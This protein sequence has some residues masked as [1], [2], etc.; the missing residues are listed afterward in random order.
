MN[1]DLAAAIYDTLLPGWR[2]AKRVGRNRELCAPYRED[3]H[4]SLHI[5]EEKLVWIDRATGEG[6]GAW[7][8]ARKMLGEDDARDLLAR[9]EPDQT[10]RPLTRRP[11]PKSANNKGSSVGC[12][13]DPPRHELEILGD[14]TRAQVEALKRTRRL[15]DVETLCRLDVKLVR[16]RFRKDADSRWS[17]WEEWLGF[18]ALSGSWKLWALNRDGIE[19]TDAQGKLIR[20]NVGPISLIPSPALR[21]GAFDPVPIVLDVEGESDLLAALEAGFT[22]VV[23]STGGAGSLGAHEANAE[24]LRTRRIAEV[25]VL[26]DRDE[27]GQRGAEKRAEWWL[28]LGVPARVPS[29]PEQLGQ[30]GDLRDYL[31]GTVAR[32]GH[33]ALEPLGDAAALTALAGA[34]PLREPEI[35]APE[36]SEQKADDDGEELDGAE[37]PESGALELPPA[38]LRGSFREFIEYLRPVTGASTAHAFASWWAVLGAC[39]GPARSGTW[40][41]RVVSVVYAIACGGTGDHKT[42]AMDLAAD[43]LPEG[44]RQVSGC[45]SDAGLFDA[46]EGDEG[47]TPQPVLLHFDELGFLLKMAALSGSTLNPMLNRLWNAPSYLDRILSKRNKDGGARRLEWPFTCLLGG[48]QPETFWRTIGDAD[49]AIASGFVNRLAVFA[50][51]PGPSLLRTAAPDECA[52]EA[53][54]LHLAELRGLQPARVALAPNAEALWDEFAEDHEARIRSLPTL[55]ASVAKRVRD[56]VARLALTYAVDGGRTEV[57]TSDLMAA[58]EVG[59]YL[60]RS[61]RGLLEGR[62]ADRG[63]GRAS[64][65]E[66]IA[67]R[68]LVKRPG[69]WQ[70]ARDLIRSWPNAQAPSSVELRRI[71]Q[72][73]DEIDRQREG[74]NERYRLTAQRGGPTRHPTPNTSESKAPSVGCRVGGASHAE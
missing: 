24:W 19:R 35:S 73:M 13:V 31:N 53:L 63:P 71:L 1:P 16:A 30:G 52:A 60:E 41:G 39:I 57:S 44:V 46:L 17:P 33:P 68:L 55:L 11:T 61:Y 49:L 23:T 62:Q 7:D 3:R 47:A 45:T 36:V 4:P 72:A 54:R 6:G 48:T 51:K 56:H 50:A 27:P 21:Q 14:P 58:I 64:D 22:Y 66:A 67:H 18:P 70:S 26:G 8:L 9:L 69:A 25:N 38:A 28:E 20:R 34:V 43:L 74:R 40:S 12:R 10:E 59:A 5:E 42:T 2:E 15:R 65:L 37:D 32:D 29:L